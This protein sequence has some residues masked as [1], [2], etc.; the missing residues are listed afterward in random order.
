MN[1]EYISKSV[2]D[3]QE[4]ASKI[5]NNLKGGEV[6]ELI[7][8]V[9]AGKTTFV[10][11]FAKALGSADRVSSPTFKICNAY[12]VKDLVVYHCDFYRLGDNDALIKNELAEMV[13]PD[14]IVLLEWSEMLNL[15]LG[16]T[17]K[18]KIDTINDTTRKFEVDY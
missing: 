2:T 5:A 15:D 8:D 11:G 13:G 12:K 1:K 16:K 4:I 6:I 7:G 18:I 10:L 14:A 17:I 3:T 9:G